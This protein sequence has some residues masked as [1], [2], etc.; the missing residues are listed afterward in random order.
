[1]AEKIDA[2]ALISLPIDASGEPDWQ[3]MED[4]MRSIMNKSEKAVEDLRKAV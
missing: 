2:E 4:Y 3:Y 1:M